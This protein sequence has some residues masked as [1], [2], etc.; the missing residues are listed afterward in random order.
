MSTASQSALADFKE[1][2]LQ[3]K[4]QQTIL[5]IAG[6]QTKNWYGNALQGSPLL[7]KSYQGILDYEPEELVI[8]VCA[9]TPLEEVELALNHHHQM[10]AFEPPHFGSLTTIGGMIAAGIAGPGRGHYGGIRDFVLGCKI[11]DGRGDILSFGGKVMKNVAGYDVSRLLP[12]SLGTLALLLEVSLKVLPKP[13]ASA[14]IQVPM[15][16]AKAITLMN[17]WAS[18]PL[19]LSAS[20]WQGDESTGTLTIRLSGA[21]AAVRSAQ[22]KLLITPDAKML[23]PEMAN[24]FWLMMREQ[25]HDFFINHEQTD[26]WRFAVNPLSP[27]LPLPGNQ[28]IEWL[29]GQRW[30]LGPLGAEQAKQMA[31][32]HGGHATLFKSLNK[33]NRGVFTQLQDQALTAP[34]APIVQRLRSTFDPDSVFQTGRMP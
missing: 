3:A 20:T 29:G 7:T 27:P 31:L 11:M 5:R 33:P 8:T 23:D 15:S 21:Q 32:A 34:L 14:T 13:V 10:L 17:T 6:G 24:Q 9:G 22:V 4:Q 1:Q 12:S 18:Q 28:C 26:L 19:P 16:Q 30:F 2:I 25:T